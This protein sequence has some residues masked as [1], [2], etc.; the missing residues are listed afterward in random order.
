MN[1]LDIVTCSLSKKRSER[2]FYVRY[3]KGGFMYVE[4]LPILYHTVPK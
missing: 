2:L 4:H 1:V 3:N